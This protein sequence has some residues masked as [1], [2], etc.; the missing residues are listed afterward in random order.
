MRSGCGASGLF[1]MTSDQVLEDIRQASDLATRGPDR[2]L[3]TLTNLPSA[4]AEGRA[5]WAEAAASA[6]WAIGPAADPALQA[7]R[8]QMMHVLGVAYHC[9]GHDRDARLALQAASAI[10]RELKRHEDEAL[11]LAVLAT[12]EGTQLDVLDAAFGILQRHHSG[13]REPNTLLPVGVP[14]QQADRADDA[15]TCYRLGL[16]LAIRI[17]D[18]A[19]PSTLR[20]DATLAL[21]LADVLTQQNHLP[22]ARQQAECGLS[23]FRALGNRRFEALALRQLASISRK[24]GRA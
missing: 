11:T 8:F 13:F 10:E 18:A 9:L 12:L 20:A 16:D 6:E 24:Q 7:V 4:L 19:T 22:E 2:E 5:D 15:V 23:G 3:T 17:G 21:C 14:L 1:A